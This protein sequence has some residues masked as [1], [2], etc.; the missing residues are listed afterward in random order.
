MEF[1]TKYFESRPELAEIL[2]LITQGFPVGK[3]I[4]EEEDEKLSEKAGKS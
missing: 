2:F 3:P 4:K 1:T